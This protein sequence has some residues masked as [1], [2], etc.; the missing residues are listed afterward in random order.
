MYDHWN[1]EIKWVLHHFLLSAT[2]CNKQW[3]HNIGWACVPAVA[4]TEMLQSHCCWERE[5]TEVTVDLTAFGTFSRKLLHDF[6]S[7]VKGS[8]TTQFL[9][10]GICRTSGLSRYFCEFTAVFRHLT[11]IANI[12]AFSGLPTSPSKG[13]K[14]CPDTPV[15]ILHSL[16]FYVVP[17]EQIL[18]NSFSEV[19]RGYTLRVKNINS[20]S[21]EKDVLQA[22]PSNSVCSFPFQLFKY[23]YIMLFNYELKSQCQYYLKSQWLQLGQSQCQLSHILT[24]K[25]CLC[26]L[27]FF[28]V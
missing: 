1:N 9:I 27:F 3:W 24:K 6:P 20:V 16:T 25:I 11:G 28:T 26:S 2:L 21:E 10:W 5:N 8:F 22:Y 15:I 17:S 23:G 7:S 13:T 14:G 18:F 19:S 4:L 12:W